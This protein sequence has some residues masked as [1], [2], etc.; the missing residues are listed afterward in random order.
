M[1]R[2]FAKKEKC[3]KIFVAVWKGCLKFGNLSGG[4]LGSVGYGEMALLE[5]SLSHLPDLKLL[6]VSRNHIGR[7]VVK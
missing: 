7:I 4:I 3:G 5:N 1:Q 2:L 6:N